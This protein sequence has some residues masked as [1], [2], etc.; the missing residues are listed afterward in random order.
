M[1]SLVL[2]IFKLS[3]GLY[4]VRVEFFTTAVIRAHVTF[5]LEI[6]PRSTQPFIPPG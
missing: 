1:S 3:V 2:L 5:S 6:F 4:N